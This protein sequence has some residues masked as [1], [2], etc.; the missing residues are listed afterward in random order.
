MRASPWARVPL[1]V[2]K[3]SPLSWPGCPEVSGASWGAGGQGTRGKGLWAS[4]SEAP[5]RHV[6]PTLSQ[7]GWFTGLAPQSCFNEKPR[8]PS[9]GSPEGTRL[10]VGEI[11]IHQRI[12]PF[13]IQN[14]I[15]IFYVTLP[16]YFA[17]ILHQTHF[18]TSKYLHLTGCIRR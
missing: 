9:A 13:I 11:L 17:Q 1:T 6:T 12:A 16:L 3:P 5:G 4:Q 14:V 8:G 2:S 7:V 18:L 10:T 15:A